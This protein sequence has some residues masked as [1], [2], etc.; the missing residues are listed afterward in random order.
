MGRHGHRKRLLLLS[1]ALIAA[2]SWSGCGGDSAQT[3]TAASLSKGAFEKQVEAI[4]K[5]GR[6]RATR[7]R[8]A[9]DAGGSEQDAIAAAIEDSILPAIEDAI[10]EIY[11]LGAPPAEVAKTEKLLVALQKGVDAGAE[12][13]SPSLKELEALLAPSGGLARKD[14]LESCVY[15]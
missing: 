8:P 15:G 2:A 12:L 7:Y 11:A 14:G 5:R 13:D 9:G 6:L 3:V 1:F 10:G 4:C